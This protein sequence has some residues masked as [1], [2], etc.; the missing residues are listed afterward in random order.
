MINLS[1]Y[2]RKRIK[3]YVIHFIML[4]LLVVTLF[5]IG[6]MIYT[7][8]KEN[9]D[10][11]I[12]KIPLSHAHNNTIDLSIDNKD[13]WILTSDGG[14]NRVDRFTLKEKD[15]ATAQTQTTHYLTDRDHIWISSANKGLLRYEKSSLK[16]KKQFDLK[17]PP[18][19]RAKV[20]GTTLA[21]N[22]GKIYF[23]M[24][25]K[26]YEQVLEFD[27]V[28]GKKTREFNLANKFSPS[29]VRC[30]LPVNDKLFVGLDKGLLEVDLS[31]G[32]IL[33]AWSINEYLPLGAERMKLLN[34]NGAARVI[35][36]GNTGAFAFDPAAGKVTG[37]IYPAAVQGLNVFGT[38]IFIGTNRGFLVYD[39]AKNSKQLVEEIY[40][41]VRVDGTVIENS[42]MAPAETLAVAFDGNRVYLG[43]TYGRVSSYDLTA[44]K[45]VNSTSARQGHIVISWVNYVDMWKNVDFGLYLR[46][47]FFICGMAML[48]SMIFATMAAYA[49]A[50]FDF[51]GSRALSMAI[52][53]TQMV[54]GIMFLIPIYS[55]FIKFSEVTGIA[56][57]GT[58]WGLI[59]VYSAFFIPFSV[60]ILRGFFAAIPVELEEAARIDGCSPFQVFWH[61]VLPL[62]I[63]GI[64]A[65]GIY[66]FLTAW[67]ELIFAWVLTSGDTMTI[68]VGIRNFVGNYQNRFDLIMAAATVATIPVMVLFFLL[69]KH[70]VKGLTAGAV[71]G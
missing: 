64:I 16:A 66:V 26:G 13:L 44:G 65:T 41:Q 21:M 53:A 20:V 58:Y 68:P 42:E 31:D 61:I 36:A 46:N 39:A 6:W 49:L 43:S 2:A 54:P 52:L 62:A 17:L 11:L 4:S 30:L 3:D 70:I 38:K 10:V 25:Y 45:M 56:I 24:Q 15:H 55:N 50:R 60:W 57:K 48:F 63:P 23:T 69:Q 5:P 34:K 1:Y 51:P 19:D 40:R 71:K 27:P 35:L 67:D 28:E 37:K 7:S 47:S 22:K 9:T 32:K 8:L 12:G 14:I 33:K 29:Q 59:F 18:F